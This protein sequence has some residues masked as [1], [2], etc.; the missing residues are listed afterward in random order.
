MS[1]ERERESGNCVLRLDDDEDED[2]EEE[3]D[4]DD[5]DIQ[6]FSKKKISCWCL[7]FLAKIVDLFK[8]EWSI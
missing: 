6:F 2:D 4:D 8:M 3:E 5:D 1:R 7:K